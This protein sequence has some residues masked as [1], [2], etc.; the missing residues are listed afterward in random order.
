MLKDYG[1][2]WGMWNLRGSFGWVDSGRPDVK[3][4]DLDGHKLDREMLEMLLTV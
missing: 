1:V 4:E 3:Y 2:G